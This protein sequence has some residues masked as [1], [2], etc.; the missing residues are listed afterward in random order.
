MVVCRFFVSG[1][2]AARYPLGLSLSKPGGQSQ[3]VRAELV[4]AWACSL[5]E[6]YACAKGGCRD[7]RPAAH[8]LF[9]LRQEKKAKEGDPKSATPSHSEGATCVGAVA[10]CAAELTARL[11]R[12][13]QTAAASQMTKLARCDALATPQPPRRRRS[14]RGWTAEQP[15]GSSLRSTRSRS[16][17]T[18]AAA[19][20]ARRLRPRDGAEQRDGPNGC[21][22]V[23]LPRPFVCAEERSGQR[24]R[25]RDC[26]SAASL[27]E[28]PLDA[29]TAGCPKR[30]A[31]TQTVGSPS[32]AFFWGW[33]VSTRA[34]RARSAPWRRKITRAAGCTKR[35]CAAGRTSR[36]PPLAHARRQ[37][38]KRAPASTGSARTGLGRVPRLRQAQPERLVCAQHIRTASEQAYETLQKK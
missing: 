20:S 24:I 4:E 11:R 21:S 38:S 5:I 23:L 2:L 19:D 33:S 17:P 37:I 6:L 27:S 18:P 3:P 15:H 30:S 36:H 14:H 34:L 22:A 31:G 26:L 28:T 9:L 13:V 25:A 1:L 12:F 8:L 16:R 29:S 7:V 35:R 32:F 10:G